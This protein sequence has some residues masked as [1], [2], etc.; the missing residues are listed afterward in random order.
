MTELQTTFLPSDW[1]ENIC[2]S[3]LGMQ[4]AKNSCFWDFAQDIHVLNIILR[5][6]PSHLTDAT[7]CNQLEA[8]LKPSLL[9]EC[10]QEGGNI[11]MKSSPK[12]P[13]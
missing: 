4:M 1:I 10:M 11:T 7:L 12:N 2:I 8:G 13:I 5:G 9:A 6:T 3:L